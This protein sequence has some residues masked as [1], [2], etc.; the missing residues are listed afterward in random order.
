MVLDDERS[1]N[2][3][4]RLKGTLLAIDGGRP[5]R[6]DKMPPRI[7]MDERELNAVTQLVRR[8][9]VEGGAFDRYEGP[10]VDLYERELAD[11]FGVAHVTCVSSGT[12]AVH[13][14]LGALDLEP[15]S[16][17][18]CSAFTDPGAVMPIIWNNS[19]PV[20]ADHDPEHFLMSPD[21]VRSVI[22]PFTRAIVVGQIHGYVANM[23]A[24][25]EIAVEHG[26]TVIGDCSQAH[27][28]TY[29]GSR[30]APFG[31]IGAVSLMSGKQMVAGGQGGMVATNDERLYWA[32]KRFADRGKPFGQAATSNTALGLNYRMHELEAVI[33]RVQ[34][35]K[36]DQIMASRRRILAGIH[37]GLGE[38]SALRPIPALDGVEIN[39]WSALFLLESEHVAVDNA[40]FARAVTEEGI[41]MSHSYRNAMVFDLE[42]MR[43]RKTFGS[44]GFP[45]GHQLGGRTIVWQEPDLP[46]ARE[47]SKKL[48][49]LPIHEC[50]TSREIDDAV[51]A[52]SKVAYAYSC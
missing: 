15:G 49:L 46:N 28:S 19:V 31:H 39:P 50:W 6:A 8:A 23:P 4:E 7:Q 22:T 35:T 1:V 5:V 25:L 36:L 20:W 41:P 12:A 40:L 47:L 38:L 17:V 43:R 52:I 2:S 18:I 42:F 51:S 10:E 30:S 13:S 37:E 29:A 9:M 34:L 24:I 45:W 44:S 33:G 11:Y 26:L 3:P 27:G 16:E 32:A 48:L 21:G 14:A